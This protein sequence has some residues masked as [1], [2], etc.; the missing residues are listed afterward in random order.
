MPTNYKNIV[1]SGFPEYVTSQIKKRGEILNTPNRSNNILEFLTN[2]NV[3][4]RLSSSVDVNG[5]SS[6]AKNN[7]LQGGTLSTNQ[8]IRGGFNETYSRGT[9]DD[10]GFKPMPGI[11]NVSIGTGGKWQTLMQADIEFICYDLDQLDRMTKLYMSLGCNVFLEWGHSNYFKDNKFEI[12][13]SSIDFFGKNNRDELLKQTTLKRKNTQG[14][15][16][17]LLGKVYNFDWS[18]NNDGS[19]NCKIQVMG[20]GGIVESL[21]I[22]TSSNVNFDIFLTEED[23]DGDYSS[24]LECILSTYKKFFRKATEEE[25]AFRESSSSE[26]LQDRIISKFVPVTLGKKAKDSDNNEITYGGYLNNIFSTITYKGPQFINNS[27]RGNENV[28]K[29]NAHQ[30]ISGLGTANDLTTSDYTGYITGQ[31]IDNNKFFQTYITLAHLFTLIQHVG[32]FSEGGEGTA[33]KPEVYLDYNPDN[34]PIKRCFSLQGSVDPSKC[35]I[36]QIGIE[37]YFNKVIEEYDL[38]KFNN[39]NNIPP[40]NGKLFN[41]LVNLDFAINTLK[42]LSTSSEDRT[43]NLMDFITRILD[44][45]NV[46]LGMVNSFRPFFDKD[47]N[48]IRIIDEH[49]LPDSKENEIIEIPNF[50]TKSLV[51]DYSFNSKISP[52]LAAQIVIAA[53][54]AGKS[55]S[56]FP[57]EILSYASLNGNIKDRLAVTKVPAVPPNKKFVTDVKKQLLPFK[58]LYQLFERVYNFNDLSVE[59]ISSLTTLYNDIQ[60]RDIK[61]PVKISQTQLINEFTGQEIFRDFSSPISTPSATP[62]LIIPIEYSI[63]IDGISG[64]LPYNIF[65]IP[66]D[67]LP[68]QYRGKVDFAVFSINHEIESNKWY[69]ILRGQI[70]IRS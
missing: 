17:C 54:A 8:N 11:T 70:V 55:L 62:T 67:R 52:K 34:T 14:N 13:P 59:N 50:G 12:N 2:R 24:D 4:F 9:S 48:C 43:V 39:R 19:Y 16:E 63:K 64:I 22:N 58:K 42:S 28:R 35:L 68:K 21:K 38:Q 26:G 10:L 15:Y 46:S 44:G 60:N 23:T 25:I 45:I 41:V 56:D 40:F 31:V 27:V 6:L 49:I 57:E 33:Q 65:R 29:G 32:I 20:S 51:Y 53:Q 18:A 30:V 36:D 47:S 7:V 37:K 66:D 5:N 3:W 1:G 61:L 69:T